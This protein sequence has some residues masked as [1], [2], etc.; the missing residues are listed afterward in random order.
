MISG[1]QCSL[2][3]GRNFSRVFDLD[4]GIVARCANCEMVRMIDPVTLGFPELSYD[5][6]YYCGGC[7]HG[8]YVDYFGVERSERRIC[9]S[10]FARAIRGDDGSAGMRAL[11]IGCGGGYLVSA[12]C[13]AGFEAVGIDSSEYAIQQ[14]RIINQ[15]EYIISDFPAQVLASGEDFGLVTMMDFIEHVRDPVSVLKHAC[16]LLSKSG[17]L[18]VMTPMY[19]G[20]LSTTQGAKYVQFKADHIH[21][22]TVETMRFAFECAGVGGSLKIENALEWVRRRTSNIEDLFVKKYA[23]EREN[24]IAVWT[25]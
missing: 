17:K 9:A 11:D 1:A 7:Q 25:P 15:G 16:D 18:V 19:G 14:A 22:F 8:G 5:S 24:M 12:L 10:V 6:A 21:H 13:C 4:F 23:D 3:A 20:R 2:C